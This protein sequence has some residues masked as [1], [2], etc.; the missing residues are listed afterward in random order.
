MVNNGA[1]GLLNLH[2]IIHNLQ[3]PNLESCHWYFRG[4][5]FVDGLVYFVIVDADCM[6]NGETR[7]HGKNVLKIFHFGYTYQYNVCTCVWNSRV[8]LDV[9]GL[10]AISFY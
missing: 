4:N 1:Y 10:M 5:G 6:L 7:R 3:I 8:E 2:T 9:Y